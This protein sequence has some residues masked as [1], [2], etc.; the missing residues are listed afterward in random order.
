MLIYKNLL[1][2]GA[3]VVSTEAA[4]TI[5]FQCEVHTVNLDLPQSFLNL[6]KWVN[7]TLISNYLKWI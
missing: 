1:D 2:S 6:N 4:V 7:R 5:L 3:A